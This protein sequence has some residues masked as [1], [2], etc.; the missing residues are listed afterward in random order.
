MYPEWKSFKDHS[1]PYLTGN[2]FA[3]QCQYIWNYDGYRVSPYKNNNWI[4]IKTDY[5][6]DFFKLFDG[7]KIQ[8][9]VVFTHN[10]DY[11]ID[12]KYR[13]YLDHPNV[14][15]WFAQNVAIDHP[16]IKPIPI[17]IADAGYAHGDIQ[18]LNKIR[19]EENP[20][21][22]Q[23]YANYSLSTNQ[24]E[25]QKC[26]DL[27]GVPMAPL[28]NGGYKGFAGGYIQPTNFEG[29]LRDMSKAYFCLSPRGNGID[30][31]RT[32]ESLYVQTIPVVTKS[33]VVNEHS[34]YPII[35]LDD[36]ADF[37][38]INFSKE[39]YDKVWDNFNTGELHMDNYLKRLSRKYQI[40]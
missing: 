26:L 39:L 32:W 31:H 1:F 9:A 37:K 16:K 23:F 36:W 33:A 35:I 17:G 5:I 2:S 3:V 7:L 34:D 10:S 30:C 14:K 20:K 24:A 15:I 28:V 25:R 12:E 18:I 38:N 4:F 29:Y 21:Q 40:S 27:T 11:Q 13:K 6:A 19:S 8:N 22:N